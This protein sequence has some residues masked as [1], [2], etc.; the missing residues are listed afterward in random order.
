MGGTAFDSP[1]AACGG[2]FLLRWLQGAGACPQTARDRF[3]LPELSPSP[4]AVAEHSSHDASA[5]F[6]RKQPFLPP[7]RRES[8]AAS[9]EFCRDMEAAAQ[10]LCTTSFDPTFQEIKHLWSLDRDSTSGRPWAAPLPWPASPTRPAW[11]V[12][13][14]R[15]RPARCGESPRLPG[16]FTVHP[17]SP[18][19]GARPNHLSPGRLPQPPEVPCPG[20]LLLKS[21]LPRVTDTRP[22]IRVQGAHAAGGGRVDS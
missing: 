2:R 21:T 18:H 19:L 8:A 20:L 10:S 16:L 17:P 9:R 13:R 6:G 5:C 14:P 1:E 11:R 22:G 3:P 4:P 12:Q 7:P 15:P